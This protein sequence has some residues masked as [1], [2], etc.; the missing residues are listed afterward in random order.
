[1]LLQIKKAPE[2]KGDDLTCYL[3]TFEDEVAHLSV[4]ENPGAEGTPLVVLRLPPL[5]RKILQ[6]L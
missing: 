1:M 2:T 3:F 5:V 6:W 4:I